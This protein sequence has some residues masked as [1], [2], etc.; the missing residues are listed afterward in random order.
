M[1]VVVTHFATVT[2]WF[3]EKDIFGREYPETEEKY[4]SI[5]HRLVVWLSFF[6]PYPWWMLVLAFVLVTFIRHVWTR[7]V[8]FS[9]TSVLLGNSIAVACGF[10]SRF[11]L[12]THF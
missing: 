7:R 3:I 2:V 5:L 6:L 9:W 4:I 1:F 10:L 11:A 12:G 8:D